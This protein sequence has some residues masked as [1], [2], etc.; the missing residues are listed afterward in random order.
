MSTTLENTINMLSPELQQEVEQ[1]VQSILSRNR[2]QK[3]QKPK[4]EWAGALKHLR[5]NYTSVELQH[6]LL[7]ERMKQP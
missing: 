2:K 6:E 1:F 3:K 7:N 4:F 5:D